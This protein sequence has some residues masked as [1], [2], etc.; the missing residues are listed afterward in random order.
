VT[1]AD[2]GTIDSWGRIPSEGRTPTEEARGATS[3][4]EEATAGEAADG[5]VGATADETAVGSAGGTPCAMGS[6]VAEAVDDPSRQGPIRDAATIGSRGPG[7]ATRTSTDAEGPSRTAAPGSWRVIKAL[8]GA[9]MSVGTSEDEPFWH[10]G[11]SPLET[12]TT[13]GYRGRGYN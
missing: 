5:S 12:S 9:S 2:E 1:I 13:A 10:G 4:E 11:S 3:S 8:M 6:A 7:E